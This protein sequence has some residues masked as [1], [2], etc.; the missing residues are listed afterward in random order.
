[1]RGMRYQPQGRLRINTRNPLARGLVGFW[2]PNGASFKSALLAIPDAAN[3]SIARISAS[4]QGLRLIGASSGRLASIGNDLRVKPSSAITVLSSGRASSVNG[5]YT[6]GCEQLNNGWGT[7]ANAGQITAYLRVGSTWASANS[8]ISAGSESQV[9][10]T[11][12]GATFYSVGNGRRVLSQAISG[13]ITNSPVG[14]DIGG[15][16]GGVASSSNSAMLYFAIWDRALSPDELASFYANPWQLFAAP[17]DEAISQVAP[18]G[19]TLIVTPASLLLGGGGVAMRVSRR[20]GVQPAAVV[21]GAGDVGTKGSR[22]LAVQPST[23]NL[24]AGDVATRAARALSAGATGLVLQPGQVQLRGARR[25]TVAPV[26]M[27]V[28]GG[29]IQFQYTPKPEAGSYVMAVTL[30]A[31]SLTG[32]GASMRVT[33]RLSVGGAGLAMSRGDVRLLAARRVGIAPAVL[34]LAAD[35]ILLRTDRRLQVEP[36]QLVVAGSSVAMRYSQQIEYARAPR[37]SGYA[38]QRV[39]TQSRPAQLGGTRPASIQRNDR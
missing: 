21:I 12:D 11:Y 29:S 13:S 22:K 10:F 37:G 35:Q 23:L 17:E 14:I 15:K 34:G 5:S 7:Y 2:L 3:T 31:L 33:R 20:I 36:A 26:S 28:T 8:N 1:M 25:L 39:E 38:P 30:A 27:V 19:D 24:F 6:F 9:G 32:G 4:S 18:G 16:G